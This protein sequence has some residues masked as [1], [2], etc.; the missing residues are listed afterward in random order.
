MSEPYI[1]GSSRKYNRHYKKYKWLKIATGVLLM[2]MFASGAFVGFDIFKDK[3]RAKPVES[4]V[5]KVVQVASKETFNTEFFRFDADVGWVFDESVSTK[6][7]FV[8]RVWR[9]PLIE[10]EFTIYVNVPQFT[11]EATHVL[12]VGIDG[13]TLLAGPVSEHCKVTYPKKGGNRNP[14]NVKLANTSLLCNPDDIRY[15]LILGVVNSGNELKLKRENGQEATYVIT[16]QDLTYS[17]N[18]RDISKMVNSF[19]AR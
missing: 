11:F 12:P 19:Q 9:G 5:Q 18:G 14:S 10:H 6:N 3:R 16:Y 7:K 15:R 2:V 17:N 1:L 13:N 8:Y 4:R